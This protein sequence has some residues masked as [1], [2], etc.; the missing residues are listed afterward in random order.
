VPSLKGIALQVL[1]LPR[2]AGTPE[3]AKA[4]ELVATYLTGLGYTVVS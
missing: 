1:A 3:A 2:E 4:R